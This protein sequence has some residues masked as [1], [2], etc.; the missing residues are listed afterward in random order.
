MRRNKKVVSLASL[1]IELSCYFNVC[2]TRR[3]AGGRADHLCI[4][5]RYSC[6]HRRHHPPMP[7]SQVRKLLRYTGVG[8]T[9][10]H[11]GY[12]RDLRSVDE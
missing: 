5:H 8:D 10:A 7:A 4:S 3:S 9:G 6:H 12:A 1:V 11:T 2:A